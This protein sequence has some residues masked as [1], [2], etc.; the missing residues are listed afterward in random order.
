MK[1]KRFI[2]SFLAVCMLVMACS[3]TL[4]G[5]AFATVADSSGADIV[6]SNDTTTTGVSL[7]GKTFDVYEVFTATV[8]GNAIEYTV[9][10]NFVKFFEDALNGHTEITYTEAA[11]TTNIAFTTAA[12]AYVAS[13]EKDM[14]TLVDQLRTYV[15]TTANGVPIAATTDT[16]VTTV[17]TVQTVSTSGDTLLGYY[18]VLDSA[19]SLAGRDV[20]DTSAVI[21]AGAL[22]TVPTYDVKGN[23]TSDATITIK[24][25]NP[26]IDKQVWH[27]DLTNTSGEISPLYN[28]NG[29]WDNVSDYEIGDTVEFRL[30][31]TMPSSLE[32]YDSVDYT[33]ITAAEF[34]YVYV[35]TDTPS[36]GITIDIDSIAVYTNA[37]LTDGV[38]NACH[39]VK[40][41]NDGGFEI[42]FDMVA[43]KENFPSLECFY[44]Y[45]TAEID[46]T[47][48]VT[49]S[50]ESNTITLE[51]STNPYIDGETTTVTDTVYTYTFDLDVF[52]TQGDGVTALDG[53]TFALYY[54]NA[55]SDTGTSQIYLEPLL[56]GIEPV[57]RDGAVVYYVTDKTGASDVM[58]ETGSPAGTILTGQTGKFTIIGLDDNTSYRLVEINAPDGYN[59]ADPISF[60]IRATYD[61]NASTGVPTLS[62][63]TSSASDIT[64]SSGNVLA[65]TVINTS[66][67][68]LPTTGG[69]G[70]TLLTYGGII[71]MVG[72]ASAFFIKR[73]HPKK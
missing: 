50:Y 14:A 40:S 3:T 16:G 9:S 27:N 10:A 42:Y 48:N 49:Q 36:D 69:M 18:L 60:T 61:I 25:S 7:T 56:N 70:T 28:T 55:G 32:G 62:L 59:A 21:T 1:T 22:V 53:A 44:I 11:S 54:A 58:P 30:T 35:L 47:A 29:D 26:T 5:T 20:G 63:R 23:L 17:G 45:Y 12:Q 2:S 6:V 67:A 34:D 64:A 57:I 24:G 15:L 65:T 72:A 31:A 41:T 8:T 37:N 71:L 52:K 19:D 38:E 33:D 73:K 46:E 4:A 43:I 51:Y 39:Y 68:M 66:S 13:Y